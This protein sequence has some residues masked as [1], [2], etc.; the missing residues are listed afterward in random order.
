MCCAQRRAFA[1]RLAERAH[2]RDGHGDFKVSIDGCHLHGIATGEAI[3]VERHKPAVEIKGAALTELTVQEDRP[4]E[5]RAQC[6]V[7]V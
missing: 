6:V 4:G 7:D 5:W 1:C 2:L 3:S